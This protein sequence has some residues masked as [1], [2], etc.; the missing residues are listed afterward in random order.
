MSSLLPTKKTFRL[1]HVAPS[2]WRKIFLIYN[3]EVF[4]PKKKIIYDR[5]STIPFLFVGSTIK[6]YSGSKFHTRVINRWM[7]GYK[8]GEFSWTRKLALYKAKQLK[9]KKKIMKFEY[10]LQIYWSKGFLIS[11]KLQTFQT[12]FNELFYLPGG[13]SWSMKKLL[14][15]RFEL[16]TLLRHPK[17]PISKFGPYFA[18][19]LNVMFSQLTSVNNTVADLTKHNLLRLYLIKTTRGRSHAL[20]KPSRG[21]RTWSNAWTAYNYNCETRAFI[22]AYQKIKRENTREEKI[23]YKITQK[24]SFIVQKKEAVS[25]VKVRVNHW[26]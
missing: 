12:N 19:T 20:G 3:N 16:Y 24:K 15:S 8:F 26:F 10:V 21:Q 11:G 25:T 22:S 14:I 18:M 13:F 6:I 5:H 4:R 17:Q 2:T 9:K 1:N 7:V 23:N